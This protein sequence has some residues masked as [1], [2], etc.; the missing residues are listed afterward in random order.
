MFKRSIFICYFHFADYSKD[1]KHVA[2][3]DGTITASSTLFGSENFLNSMTGSWTSKGLEN[4]W[5]MVQF[6]EKVK[7]GGFK[8]IIPEGKNAFNSHAFQYH[9]GVEW[10]TVYDGNRSPDCCYWEKQTFSH[11]SSKRFRL[12][13]KEAH[14]KGKFSIQELK[15]LF[16]TG[17]AFMKNFVSECLI[18][19]FENRYE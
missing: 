8:T 6:N 14:A 17:E 19:S 1:W 5:I 7:I 10:K 2:E 13:L 12:V 11:K 9:D 16:L 18:I 4:E 3:E 15:L